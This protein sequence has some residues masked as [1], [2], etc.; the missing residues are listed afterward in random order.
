MEDQPS[1]RDIGGQVRDLARVLREQWWIIL[2]CV[3]LTTF[4]AA[5]YTSSLKKEYEATAKLLLQP[6]NLS[7][8]IAGASVPGVD[9]TR[10]AA[11][12]AQLVGLPVVARRVTET[13]NQPLR[14][15]A[16]S[17]S[18]GADSNILTVTVT[19]HSPRRAARFANEFARQYIVFRRDS[20]RDRYSKAL[21][22]VQTRLAQTRPRTPDYAAL[23]A[24]VKQ[25]RLLVSLQTG[26]AQIVAAAS[27]PDEAVRPEP[28]RNIAIGVVVGLLLGLALAF[29]RDRLDRR[30]KNED[31]IEQ[32]LTGVPVIGLVPQPRRGRASKLMTA[33][34][35]HTLQ[36]NLALLSRDHPLKTLLVTSATPAE[37]KSTV[38]LNLG[39]AMIEKGQAALVIDADLRR[40]SL[41]ER[42][43]V[44]RRVGVSSILA[45]DGT[46]E[47]S[48]QEAAVEPA[49]NGDGPTVSIGGNLPVVTAGPPAP[50]VQLLLND[51]TLGAL[52]AAT[53][54]RSECV[55]F[56][57]PPV[58]SFSDML[59]LA[60]EVD[61]VIVVVRLYH[62]RKDQVRRFASQLA[63]AGIKPIGVVVL[64][65]ASGPTRYYA[66][67]LKR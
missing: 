53:R 27:P 20:A 17:T 34:G 14:E 2:L 57:G 63:N 58:G 46:L 26:D 16:V 61:G 56:D 32:L 48:V 41:S 30:L 25:L 49:R 15:A 9:P 52:L 36:A 67:Y 7:S 50:N 24:Q 4:A 60:R 6:D 62:S 65:A 28:E 37:G 44:D 21:R 43:K 45:G 42:L 19:D 5:A 29:L 22:T 13:L 40:P 51:R 66:D 8:T 10:Q 54:E 23:R 38:A 3:V 35:F 11:T 12:D 64:G 33:E 39:L 59:P 47:T 18:A 55:I 1:G 31:Q